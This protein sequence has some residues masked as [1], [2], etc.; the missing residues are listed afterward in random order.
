M[1]YLARE[2]AAI[3]IAL[4]S[5]ADRDDMAEIAIRLDEVLD[6]LPA[7]PPRGGGT[8]HERHG[9]ATRR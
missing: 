3:R 8:D 9:E 2:I 1:D 5:K 4:E 6:R 7:A